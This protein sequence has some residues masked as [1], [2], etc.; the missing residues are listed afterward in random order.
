MASPHM[1]PTASIIAVA[2]ITDCLPTSRFVRT[3]ST[4][5]N[6]ALAGITITDDEFAFGDYGAGRYA[7]RLENV[8]RLQTP[9]GRLGRPEEIAATIAFLASDDASFFVGDT[10]SPN[11]GFVTS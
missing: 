9:Q 5:E 7:F 6:L 4:K 1:L 3:G 8:V 2:E 11:G 10:V